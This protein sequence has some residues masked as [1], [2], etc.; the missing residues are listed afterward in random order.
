M[1]KEQ[2]RMSCWYS[3]RNDMLML[4]CD[5]CRTTVELYKGQ[6]DRLLKHDYMR[7]HGWRCEKREEKW[8]DICPECDAAIKQSRREAWIRKEQGV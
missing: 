4:R 6:T 7:S 2:N 8:F 1:R 3:V 5:V